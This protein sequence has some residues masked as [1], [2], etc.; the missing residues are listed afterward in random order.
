MILTLSGDDG[1]VYSLT[2]ADA[3]ADLPVGRYC[4]SVLYVVVRPYDGDRDWQFTFSRSSRIRTR[5]WI[6][7]VKGESVEYD[8]IGKLV[9][10]ATVE[11][12]AKQSRLTVQPRL[13]T[14]SGLLINLCQ[15]SGTSAYGGQHCRIRL[16]DSS[17]QAVGQS[18]SGFA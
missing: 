10:D 15:I 12:P 3:E 8:P 2:D 5:D 9:L 6:E 11:R 18:S 7:I 1:S 4:A 16:T 14:G 13:F 17:D